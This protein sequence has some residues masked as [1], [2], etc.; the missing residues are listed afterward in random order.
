MLELF[1]RIL[2]KYLQSETIQNVKVWLSMLMHT[3]SQSVSTVYTVNLAFKN[4]KIYTL[5]QNMNGT[6]FTL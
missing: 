3:I 2:L 5:S 4:G 1:S 6:H